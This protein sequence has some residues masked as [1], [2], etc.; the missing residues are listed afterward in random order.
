MGERENP[1]GTKDQKAFWG[2]EI[3]SSKLEA[4]LGFFLF[5]RAAFKD[6]ESRREKGI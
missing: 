3:V 5:L 4:Y 2:R 6:K 1:F